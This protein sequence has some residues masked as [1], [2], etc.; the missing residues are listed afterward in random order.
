MTRSN[1]YRFL[2]ATLVGTLLV[3][4]A[5]IAWAQYTRWVICTTYP[6]GIVVCR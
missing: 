1:L 6:S 5:A 4:S 2:T 3:G